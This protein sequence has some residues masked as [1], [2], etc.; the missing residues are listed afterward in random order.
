[1]RIF[2]FVVGQRWAERRKCKN[3]LEGIGTDLWN[4]EF[5]MSMHSKP[6]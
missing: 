5:E 6:L 3:H 2:E 4:T 1:M